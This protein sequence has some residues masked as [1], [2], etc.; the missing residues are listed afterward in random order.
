MCP[1][2]DIISTVKGRGFAVSIRLFCKCSYLLLAITAISL[3]QVLYAEDIGARVAAAAS[4]KTAPIKNITNFSQALRCMDNLFLQHD[5]KG[6]VITSAGIPDMTGKVSTGTKEMLITA[7]SKM[8][9]KSKAFDFID[10]HRA[11]DDL[12]NLFNLRGSGPTSL[13][14][15]YIRGSITQMD[16]SAIRDGKGGGIALPFLDLGASTTKQYDLL[17]I[18]MSVGE[19]ASRRILPETS[20]ANTMIITKE[21][22]SGEA[23]GKIMKMGLS[24]NLDLAKSEGVGAATRTL[25]E[26]GLIETLGRFTKVPYWKCLDIPSNN[27]SM[28]DQAREWYDSASE[29][30]R[31]LFYQRKFAG[32]KRYKGPIDGVMN[33]DLKS[34]VPEYQAA[35]GLTADGKIN[36]ELY[37]SL[38]DDDQNSLVAL[39]STQQKRPAPSLSGAGVPEVTAPGALAAPSNFKPNLESDRGANP[40]YKIGDSLNLSF[41]MNLTGTVYCYYEDV[42]KNTARL[43]PNRFNT[44]AFYKGGKLKLPGDGFKIQ[45]DRVGLERVAC[46]A[47][48]RELVVPA[49]LRGTKDLTA[50]KVKSLDEVVSQFKSNNPVSTA[51]M[52]EITVR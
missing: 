30:D 24:F 49:T 38:L 34:A 32:M 4:A 41:S 26:L 5:K 23:G 48:D 39:P 1:V 29:K 16:D 40:V 43:F 21:G 50:L 12:G 51:S 27:P 33:E 37:Y 17:S 11:D 6:I 8:T 7:I 52:I 18:D 22:K 15:Y 44:D 28:M 2:A 20:T 10:L 31:V 19:A 36:F 14:D 42:G 3:S 13:P 9:I 35:A 25:V 46:I 45:F 47:A